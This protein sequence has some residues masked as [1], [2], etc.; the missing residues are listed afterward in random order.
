MIFESYKANVPESQQSGITIWTLSDNAA[1]H[2]YW[3]SGDAPNLSTQ[4]MNANMPIK[5]YAMVLPEKIS[6][7]ISAV[8]TGR[9]RM[10]QKEKKL[11]LNKV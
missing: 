6:V 3:L 7:Q 1:E 9:M 8:T 4:T 10:K 2:E 11:R 5:A